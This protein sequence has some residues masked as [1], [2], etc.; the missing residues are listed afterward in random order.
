MPEAAIG[1]RS[2]LGETTAGA[3]VGGRAAVEEDRKLRLAE[4]RRRL[5]ARP[6]DLSPRRRDRGARSDREREDRGRADGCR[7]QTGAQVLADGRLVAHGAARLQHV[8]RPQRAFDP[9][10]HVTPVAAVNAEPLAA[11]DQ[12]RAEQPLAVLAQ[13]RRTRRVGKLGAKPERGHDERG[14]AS[15]ALRGLVRLEHHGPCDVTQAHGLQAHV[16]RASRPGFLTCGLCRPSARSDERPSQRSPK[17]QHRDPAANRLRRDQ[18]ED[19][20]RRAHRV[21]RGG[22]RLAIVAHGSPTR[23]ADEVANASRIPD[24]ILER[25]RR[26][27]R[28]GRRSQRLERHRVARPERGTCGQ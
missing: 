15:D 10:D 26:A 4:E 14:R 17:E 12:R 5:R 1:R 3:G 18:I 2:P 6:G 16:A 13:A 8:D 23:T 9:D 22:G 27:K 20:I 11:G 7:L 21:D 28:Q 19:A 24:A 25:S